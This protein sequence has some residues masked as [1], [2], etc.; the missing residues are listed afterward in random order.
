MKNAVMAVCMLALSLSLFSQK[1]APNSDLRYNDYI[2]KSKRQKR[3]GVILM[4]SGALV[5]TGGTL[6]ILDAV[7]R[8]KRSG[9]RNGSGEL[10]VGDAEMVLGA[11]ATLVGIAAM[12]ASIPFLVGARRS[13]KK[14]L[15]ISFKT[16]T[17]PL[18]FKMSPAGSQYPALVCRLSIGH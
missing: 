13:R 9:E 18:L 15:A 8:N 1:T 16:E 7:N 3:A 5:T 6:I 2:Q 11:L 10:N 12:S 4:S 14:A 17:V